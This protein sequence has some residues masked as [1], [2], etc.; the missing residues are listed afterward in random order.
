MHIVKGDKVVMTNPMER[1]NLVGETLEVANINEDGTVILRDRKTKIALCAVDAND[2]YKYFAKADSY[3]KWTKWNTI[4]NS[5]D[6]V[7][8]YYKTNQKKVIVKLPEGVSAMASCN[9]K[10]GEV[11]NLGTGIYIAYKRCEIKKMRKLMKE[12]ESGIVDTKNQLS[13]FLKSLYEDNEQ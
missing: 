4:K 13:G 2:F 7:M 3:K 8:A 6:E 9:E 10:H 5:D 12:C 1:L 11:F